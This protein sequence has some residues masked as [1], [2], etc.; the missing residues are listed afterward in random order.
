[1]IKVMII[2]IAMTEKK[3]S[4]WQR[5]GVPYVLTEGRCLPRREDVVLWFQLDQLLLVAVS[6]KLISRSMRVE[7]HSRDQQ[8][9]EERSHHIGNE[10][11]IHHITNCC[12]VSAIMI[13]DSLLLRLLLALLALLALLDLLDLLDLLFSL[14]LDLLRLS[15]SNSIP[16]LS[17]VYL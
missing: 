5:E 17:S 3:A 8:N 12:K 7:E 13:C 6:H 15:R 14:F 10:R 2:V 16:L 9:T 1:M 4:H 11:F